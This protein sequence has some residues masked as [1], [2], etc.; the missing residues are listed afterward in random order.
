M[1]P[2]VPDALQVRFPDLGRADE[3]TPPW[4]AALSEIGALRWM[5][6]KGLRPLTGGS[7]VA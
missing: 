2:A 5:N 1:T 4:G 6:L 7:S 3:V